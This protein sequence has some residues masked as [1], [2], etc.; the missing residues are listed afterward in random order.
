MAGDG[1]TEGH[2]GVGW[3]E[4]TRGAG[5][6]HEEGEETICRITT[7]IETHLGPPVRRARSDKT[8]RESATA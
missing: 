4:E 7:H 1:R 8:C 6:W 3:Y 5:E 2:V